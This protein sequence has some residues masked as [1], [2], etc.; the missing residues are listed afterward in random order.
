M[1]YVLH[2]NIFDY[3]S[4]SQKNDAV[5]DVSQ[6]IPIGAPSLIYESY[7]VEGFTWLI[8]H[9]CVLHLITTTFVSNERKEANQLAV[10]NEY[11]R[12]S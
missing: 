11:W 9:H 1:K 8:I 4:V 2:D 10:S 6:Q 5:L 3:S 7:N 12:H